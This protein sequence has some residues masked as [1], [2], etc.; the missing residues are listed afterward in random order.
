MF[1]ETWIQKQRKVRWRTFSR[2]N[3]PSVG[4]VA[5]AV[6]VRLPT[7]RASSVS[8]FKLMSRAVTLCVKAPL[9]REREARIR[10]IITIESK[11][12]FTSKA[13][14]GHRTTQAHCIH[15]GL[16]LERRSWR[17]CQIRVNTLGRLVRSQTRATSEHAFICQSIYFAHRVHR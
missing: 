7:W 12:E 15:D 6:F 16:F 11:A 4:V 13:Y 1:H 14:L 17:R 10:R 3:I 8:M 9:Q 2:D 5:Y